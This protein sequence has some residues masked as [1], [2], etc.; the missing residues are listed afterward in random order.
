VTLHERADG[1][2]M[3]TFWRAFYYPFKLVL[4]IAMALLRKKKYR[5]T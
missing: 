2:T 4:A 1:E 3:F 5:Q